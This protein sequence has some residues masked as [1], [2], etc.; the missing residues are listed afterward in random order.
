[1]VKAALIKNELGEFAV[2]KLDQFRT[3]S[4]FWEHLY[5]GNHS[6]IKT[7]LHQVSYAE[8]MLDIFEKNY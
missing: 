2:L 1:M 7:Y 8:I 4:E 3:D 5:N 6:I